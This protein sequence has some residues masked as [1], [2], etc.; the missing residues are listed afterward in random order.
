MR[1][2]LLVDAP[3]FWARLREDLHGAHSSAYVQTFSF[4]GDRVGTALGR[5]LEACPAADRRLLVDGF[6]LLYH[7]DRL[8]PGPAWL[9]RPFR[10]EVLLTHRWV[11]RL[12]AGGVGVR[13]GNPIGPSPVRLLR[14]SH[15]KLAVVDERVAYLGGINFSDH[16]FAWHDMMLRVESDQLGR[17]LAE[18]FRASWEGR[19][20]TLDAGVGPLRILALNGRGN[21][22]GMRPVVDAVRGARRTIDVASAYL[23]H[24]FTSH[25]AAASRRGVHVRVLTPARNNKS[26]L[27]RHVLHR[28]HRH[29][30]EVWRYAGGMSHLKAMLVDGELLVAGSSNF[31]F[32]SYHILEEL[33]VMTRDEHVVRGFQERVWGPDLAS[34][35]PGGVR[36]SVGTRLGD[37][38][39][40]IGAHLA[41]LLAV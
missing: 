25:L 18:D 29:G 14:R 16:N 30:F 23:S 20:T 22:R 26:N 21:A 6:S 17:I 34:A 27:A 10:R 12:R 15:K 40:R 11:R 19:P 37:L 4:E 9:E 36:A 33:V 2:E 1:I 32:M 41:A 31:D 38:A 8:I 13:F 39:V 3:A 24:P 28:A 7:N 35:L 5:T